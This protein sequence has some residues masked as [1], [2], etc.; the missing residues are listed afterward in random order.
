LL[1]DSLKEELD[2]LLKVQIIL[3]LFVCGAVSSDVRAAEFIA[4][5][6]I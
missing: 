5:A 2:F 4:E 1:L 3:I 6:G